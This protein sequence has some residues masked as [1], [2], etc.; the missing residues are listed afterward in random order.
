M[1]PWEQIGSNLG[2]IRREKGLT[3]EELRDLTDVSQQYLSKLE[4]GLRNPTITILMKIAAGLN[5]SLF[6]L[7]KGLEETP[8]LSEP[9]KKRLVR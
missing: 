5:V 6:A 3:Q 1:T 9:S 4:G 8:E 7:L 2:R